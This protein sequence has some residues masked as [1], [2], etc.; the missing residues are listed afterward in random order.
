MSFA[1]LLHL[2]LPCGLYSFSRSD[3]VTALVNLLCRALLV[4]KNARFGGY[5][6]AKARI[7]GDVFD[8]LALRPVERVDRQNNKLVVIMYYYR[9]RPSKLDLYLQQTS[10][11]E[12][13]EL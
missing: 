10:T 2:R 4:F 9:F 5:R 13:S 7:G 12:K 6:F 8:R 3:T 1:T 11:Q